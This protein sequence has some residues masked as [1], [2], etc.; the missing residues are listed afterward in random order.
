MPTPVSQRTSRFQTLDPAAVSSSG[1]YPTIYKA[2]IAFS[3]PSLVAEGIRAIARKLSIAKQGFTWFLFTHKGYH[4]EGTLEMLLPDGVSCSD[5]VRATASAVQSLPDIYGTPFV[6]GHS[7]TALVSIGDAVEQWVDI[8]PAGPI[9][10]GK[11]K[12]G[13][14]GFDY[15]PG[16]GNAFTSAAHP[17]AAALGGS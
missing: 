11:L 4:T 3:E 12:L 15:G 14:A 5:A 6:K 1:P 8:N 13:P 2:V 16:E 17:V 9:W 10:I 7:G